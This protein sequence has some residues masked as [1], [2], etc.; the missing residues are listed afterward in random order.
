MNEQ[1]GPEGL[2][3]IYRVLCN[4]AHCDGDVADREREVL[5]RYRSRFGL[6]PDEAQA[7]EAGALDPKSLDVRD[8][9]TERD[10]LIEGMIDVV[11]AD[12]QLDKSEQARLEE[13]FELLP[14]DTQT[15]MNQLMDK[16]MS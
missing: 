7:L 11:A 6:T 8:E 12:R 5:E 3:R 16:F 9:P 14:V 13:L 2:R 4:L 10:L 1:V 15:F